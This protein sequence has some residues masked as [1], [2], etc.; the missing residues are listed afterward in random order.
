MLANAALNDAAGH[1]TKNGVNYANIYHKIS[2]VPLV[3]TPAISSGRMF[4]SVGSPMYIKVYNNGYAGPDINNS[5]DP[6][7]DIY[8]DFIE[9]TLDAGG[10]HGNTT[11]VDAFGF[12]ITH[13]LITSD[14]YDR[15]VGKQKPVQLYSQHISMR[16]LLNLRHWFNHLTEYWHLPRVDLKRADLMRIILTA[17]LTRS[18]MKQG[19]SRLLRRSE[20]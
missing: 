15:T 16:C 8:W 11:R 14:G 13:R 17:M 7:N 10:Y 6:N 5:T 20:G 1:L 9:F 3:S 19:R 18:G 12:P 2:E 4:L